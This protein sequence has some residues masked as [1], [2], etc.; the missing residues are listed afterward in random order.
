MDFMFPT[1]SAKGCGM[2]GA[3]GLSGLACGHCFEGFFCGGYGHF[4][5]GG[6]VG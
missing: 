4:D 2:S 6:A 1:H 3:P 5:F